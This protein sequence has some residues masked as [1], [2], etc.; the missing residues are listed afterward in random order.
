MP[1]AD[2]A[3]KIKKTNLIREKYN[4]NISKLVAVS[5]WLFTFFFFMSFTDKLIGA[6]PIGEGKMKVGLIEFATTALLVQPLSSDKSVIESARKAKMTRQQGIRT[7]MSKATEIA[8]AQLK[9]KCVARTLVVITDGL[10][11]SRSASTEQFKA[12]KAEGIKVV[13]VTVGTASS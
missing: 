10:P 12:A 11:S 7:Y 8:R 5:A 4:M 13:M 1:N 6:L 9:D 3:T 2:V